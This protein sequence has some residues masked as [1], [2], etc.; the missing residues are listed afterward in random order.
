VRAVDAPCVPT[1][2]ARPAFGARALT[3][4]I[5]IRLG[6][7]GSI[8]HPRILRHHAPPPIV[9]PTGWALQSQGP[10]RG[11]PLL[12]PSATTTRQRWVG[13]GCISLGFHLHL[14]TIA[15]L[16]CACV[17]C[18]AVVA[19]LEGVC[20]LGRVRDEMMWGFSPVGE[21]ENMSQSVLGAVRCSCIVN[22]SG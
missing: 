4:P 5:L 12:N 13:A 8:R 22:A 19:H 14:S 21:P 18:V 17:A 20:T 9:F 6:G 10:T 15:S 11:R 7:A 3:L 2:P 16:S 1:S